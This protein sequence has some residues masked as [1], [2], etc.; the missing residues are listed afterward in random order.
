M[1]TEYCFDMVSCEIYV[2][3]NNIIK[4]DK[5]NKEFIFVKD[6]QEYLRILIENI[7]DNIIRELPDINLVDVQIM[8]FN[9]EFLLHRLVI[10]IHEFLQK[11]DIIRKINLHE[12]IIVSIH[13]RGENVFIGSFSAVLRG[14]RLKR[15]PIHQCFRQL[16]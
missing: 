1:T 4:F 15:L 3:E 12:K 11:L 2:K 5:L 8:I 14:L 16:W 7:K 6:I 10:K 9:K 13:H